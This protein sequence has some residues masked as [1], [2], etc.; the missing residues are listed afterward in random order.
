[1][2]VHTHSEDPIE[3]VVAAIPADRPLEVMVR[4]EDYLPIVEYVKDCPEFKMDYLIDVTAIDYDDH[5]DMVTMLRSLE[6]GHKLFLCVQ[7]KRTSAFPKKNAP[8]RFWQASER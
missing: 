5:F 7:L 4:P 2:T 1:M 6:H 3:D 8:R